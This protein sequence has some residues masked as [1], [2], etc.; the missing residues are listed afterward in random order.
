MNALRQWYE[1]EFEAGN[2]LELV[3][4]FVIRV[5]KIKLF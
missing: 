2:R 5:M 3:I 1:S 4:V